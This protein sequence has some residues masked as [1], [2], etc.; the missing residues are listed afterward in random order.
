VD[1]VPSRG[2]TGTVAVLSTAPVVG[3]VPVLLSV[4]LVPCLAHHEGTFV[5]TVTVTSSP[6][7]ETDVLF[8]LMF[9]NTGCTRRRSFAV[10]LFAVAVEWPVEVNCTV[11]SCQPGRPVSAPAGE[12]LMLSSWVEAGVAVPRAVVLPTASVLPLQTALVTTLS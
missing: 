3:A 10:V 12:N 8:T 9:V 7:A 2:G 4:L 5:F 11:V 1:T 6:A